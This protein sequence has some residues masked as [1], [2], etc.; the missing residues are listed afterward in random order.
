MPTPPRTREAI[1]A[2]IREHGPMTTEEIADEL[3]MLKSTVSSCISS[4]RS[5]TAKH[6]YIKGFRP[7][8]G[9]AGLPAALFAVGDRKDAE[10]PEPD[11]KAIARRS[12]WKRKGLIKARRS[13]RAQSPFKSMITQLVTS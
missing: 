11:R 5:T 6:F 12:Y 4:S 13:T 2:L 1:K 8:L 9:R 7:Q 3:G 10:P